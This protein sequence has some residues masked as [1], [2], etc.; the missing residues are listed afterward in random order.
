MEQF[1]KEILDEV[2]DIIET[3]YYYKGEIIYYPN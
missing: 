3:S 2:N 1:S